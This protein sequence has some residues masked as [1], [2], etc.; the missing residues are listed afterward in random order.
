MSSDPAFDAVTRARNQDNGGNPEGAVKTLEDY[1]AQDPHNVYVRMEMARILVYSL[2]NRE[3]GLFQL[4]IILDL[5]PD[6]IDA[7]K[8]SATVKSVERGRVDE[9]EAEFT[10]LVELTEAKGD[11]AEIASV[12]AAYAVFLRK[13]KRDYEKAAEYYEKAVTA[14]PDRYEYHQDY[15]VLLLN[16]YRDYVR[17]RHELEEV[18]RIKPNH[19]SARKNLEKL[20]ATK[21]DS[22]GNVRLSFL[23]KRRLKR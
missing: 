12:C 14:E 6:N 8:A 19:I 16:E 21:F 5:D 11:R 22:E 13:Q 3:Q 10:R 7:L 9:A 15:A 17:A 23:E 2:S 1:L 20:V 18:L 4:G